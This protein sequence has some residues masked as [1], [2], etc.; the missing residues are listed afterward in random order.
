MDSHTV[1]PININFVLP[2]CCLEADFYP[3]WL[4]NKKIKI[5]NIF[6]KYAFFLKHTNNCATSFLATRVSVLFDRFSISVMT[7]HCKSYS[8]LERSVSSNSFSGG[9]KEKKPQTKN[10]NKTQN[11][12]KILFSVQQV[13]TY[14]KQMPQEILERCKN[15]T[16]N[17]LVAALVRAIT[18]RTHAI[19]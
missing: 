4:K 11:I 15:T 12:V 13:T 18:Q 10:Q 2:A 14:I 9:K 16:T 8:D 1:I 19:N 5:Q 6:K 3:T 17:F 7:L